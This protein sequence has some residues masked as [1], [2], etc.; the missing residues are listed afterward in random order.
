MGSYRAL[1]AERAALE[2]KIEQARKREIASVIKQ[3]NALIAEYQLTPEELTFPAVEDDA[4]A[5]ASRRRAGRKAVAARKVSR[6]A[7]PK[8]PAAPPKYINPETGQTWNGRGRAPKWLQG[9]RE[10]YLIK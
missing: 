5:G 7:A 8:E 6:K 3:I 10:K 9:D 2:R 1:L 4:A